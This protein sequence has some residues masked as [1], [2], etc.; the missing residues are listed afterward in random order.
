M[1]V[2]KTIELDEDTERELRVLAKGRRVEARLHQRARIV[3]LAAQGMQNKDIA[4]EVGLDRR[5]V[6]LWRERFLEG[7]IDALR[8]DAPRSGRPATVRAEM[9]SHI[10]HVTLHEKPVDATHWS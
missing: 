6:A 8:Q 10:V 2:A 5:Q 1:R 9:E 3:L 4:V 7:G